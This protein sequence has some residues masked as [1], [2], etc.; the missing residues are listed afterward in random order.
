M[1]HCLHCNKP[2][3]P[4]EGFFSYHSMTPPIPELEKLKKQYR[5]DE[6]FKNLERTDLTPHEGKDLDNLN[7]YDQLLNTVTK[8]ILCNSCYEKDI[9]LLDKYYPSITLEL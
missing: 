7:F 8:G 9:E 6:W 4:E 5:G 3:Q 1:T 2:T